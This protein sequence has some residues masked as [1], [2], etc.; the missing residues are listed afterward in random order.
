[1]MMVVVSLKCWKYILLPYRMLAAVF[2]HLQQLILVAAA[3]GGPVRRV[4]MVTVNGG[5]GIMVQ[6]EALSSL[7]VDADVLKGSSVVPLFF[8]APYFSSGFLSSSG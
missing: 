2:P 3:S 5:A 1:M 6:E 8:S 7:Q 4:V